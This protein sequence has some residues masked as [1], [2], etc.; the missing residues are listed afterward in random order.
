VRANEI[1]APLW[2]RLGYAPELIVRRKLRNPKEILEEFREE[3]ERPE[4]EKRESIRAEWETE[5]RSTGMSAA[6]AKRPGSSKSQ[7]GKEASVFATG[8]QVVRRTGIRHD[9]VERYL[10]CTY[11][12]GMK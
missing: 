11:G 12:L 5:E 3:Q 2:R 6:K 8:Q 1:L 7:G 4:C 9:V 10:E